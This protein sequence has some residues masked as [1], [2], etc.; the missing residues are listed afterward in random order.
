MNRKY[1]LKVDRKPVIAPHLFVSLPQTTALPNIVDL[2]NKWNF[3]YDQGAIGSCTSVAICSLI[4]ADRPTL[5]PSRLFLYYNER[6][7]DGDIQDDAGSTLTQ[8][9]NALVHYGICQ[10]SLWPY[11]VNKF[12]DSPPQ[13]AFTDGMRHRI[14]GYR[15]I[16][17]DLGSIKTALH[18]RIPF[19]LGIQ[20]YA[21]FESDHASRTG[22]IPY[23]N[24]RT[25]TYLGGHAIV[26]SGYDD[27]R[28][29]FL[30]R[31]SWGPR[32][33]SNGY[34]YIPYRYI[35][36]RGLTSDLWCIQTCS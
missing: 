36:D 2:R 20:V 1:N 6:A 25:E 29:L 12:A 16:P 14:G 7:L 19:V 30:F 21:S 17:Q 5:T 18:N 28:G 26:I 8:G 4:K 33:G 27:L 13:V 31:N 35:L 10:E 3:V 11:N 34:G 24:V 22:M 32:W 23:P 9:V 15:H